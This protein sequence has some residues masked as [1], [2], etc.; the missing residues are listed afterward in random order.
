MEKKLDLRVQKTYKSLH[1]AFSELLEEKTFED[2]TVLELCERAM[3]RKNTFYLH[4]GDKYEYFNYY[5]SELR[6]EFKNNIRSK[7]EY[8]D[9]NDYSIYMLQELFQFTKEHQSILKR[10]KQS[11]RMSFLY[12]ALQEQVSLELY[13]VMININKNKPSPELDLLISFYAGGIVNTTYWWLN[14][15]DKLD[16]S[17]IA[18]KLLQMVPLPSKI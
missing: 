11:N 15:P 14:N 4:F 16:E 18:E 12:E 8:N 7:K 6:E 10:L 9:P 3:I 17:T 13:N 1:T 2:F 5:L